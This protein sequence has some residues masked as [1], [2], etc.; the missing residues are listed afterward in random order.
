MRLVPA[1]ARAVD[2]SGAA[3]SPDRWDRAVRNGTASRH[4]LEPKAAVLNSTAAAVQKLATVAVA[5]TVS[6]SSR[7]RQGCRG[8][9]SGDDPRLSPRSVGCDRRPPATAVS[10]SHYRQ[11][12]E[13][14]GMIRQEKAV[15]SARSPHI[16]SECATAPSNHHRCRQD[17][18][19]HRPLG[20]AVPSPAR[21]RPALRLNGPSDSAR[22]VLTLPGRQQ[23]QDVR[24]LTTRRSAES[25]ARTPPS[26]L[27]TEKQHDGSSGI[28]MEAKQTTTTQK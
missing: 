17:T 5:C 19:H 8:Y 11:A 20:C 13:Q 23:V 10:C 12:K 9:G 14:K 22:R 3:R 7:A 26:T 1:T 21:S 4:F 6:S 15:R 25:A 18:R 24:K 16:T 28:G 27:L 2:M